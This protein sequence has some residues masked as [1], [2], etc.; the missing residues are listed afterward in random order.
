MSSLSIHSLLSVKTLDS[1]SAWILFFPGYEPLNTEQPNLLG[2]RVALH[3]MCTSHRV[4]IVNSSGIVRLNAYMCRCH[5]NTDGF[6]TKEY[7]HEFETAT[8]IFRFSFNPSAYCFFPTHDC[9]PTL[10]WGVRKQINVNLCVLVY[11][12]DIQLSQYYCTT[13]VVLQGFLAI[14]LHVPGSSFILSKCLGFIMF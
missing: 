14:I 12:W 4:N 10:V 9:T 1:L 8:V 11:K 3:R 6:Q 13:T 5:V 2:D 7:S